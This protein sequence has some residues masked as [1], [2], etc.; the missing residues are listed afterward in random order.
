MQHHTTNIPGLTFIK[1]L[2]FLTENVNININIIHDH[3]QE[4]N[5]IVDSPGLITTSTRN[6]NL[7][8]EEQLLSIKK[9]FIQINTEV[10]PA[11]HKRTLQSNSSSTSS[12]AK[13]DNVKKKMKSELQTDE[14]P[15][16]NTK[17]SLLPA[18][19]KSIIF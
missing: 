11:R 19:L 18:A 9:N 6:I 10:V 12:G 3:R 16:Q 14:I 2:A 1:N 13:D 7:N 17:H 15:T 5:D 4:Y 8:S